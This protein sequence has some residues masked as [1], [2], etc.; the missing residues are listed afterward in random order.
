MIKNL[1]NDIILETK[2]LYKSY[3]QGEVEYEILRDVNFSLKK[4]EI[5][6][7]IG[8][9]G[10]GKTSLLNILGM[11]DIPTS[12]EVFINGLEVSSMNDT[13]KTKLRG[14]NIGFVFQFHHLFQDFT[15]LENV[16][17][18]LKIQKVENNL[19]KQKALHILKQMGLESRIN[20]YPLQLSGGEQQRVAI[21]R[22]IV[23]NPKILIADEPTGNLDQENSQ[24]V[25]NMLL[26]LVKTY[27]ISVILATHEV[28]IASQISKKI[29]IENKNIISF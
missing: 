21:A 8:P 15:A 26:D 24:M 6:G 28:N 13:Q 17:F 20:N 9:S 11:L 29:K 1:S 27:E 12:G 22:A 16:M 7:L 25:F 19:A 4:G 23:F 18:P 2:N 10:S 3:N 14:Q 5:L